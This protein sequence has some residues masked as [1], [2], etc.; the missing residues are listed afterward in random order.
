[1]KLMSSLK[2]L[3]FYFEEILFMSENSEDNDNSRNGDE[4]IFFIYSKYL[5]QIDAF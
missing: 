3:Q 5:I 1:M 4:Y 2:S